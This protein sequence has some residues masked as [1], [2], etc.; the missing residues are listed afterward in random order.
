VNVAHPDPSGHPVPLRGHARLRKRL[1]ELEA[2][3]GRA[4]PGMLR[5]ALDAL[6]ESAAALEDAAEALARQEREAE[7]ERTRLQGQLQRAQRLESIGR[8]AGGI[9][10]DLNNLLGPIL[11]YA[12]LALQQVPPEE[13]LHADLREIQKLGERARQLGRHLLALGRRQPLTLRVFSLN[14]L[15]AELQSILRRTIREDIGLELALGAAPDSVRGDAAQIEQVLL[16]L[17]ANAQDAMPEGGTLTI[18]TENTLVGRTGTPPHP[19]LKPGPYVTLVVSDTGC[20]MD[21]ETLGHLFEPFFTTKGARGTGLGLASA[22]GVVRQHAGR[23]GVE[24][25]PQAGTTFRIYLPGVEDLPEPAPPPAPA[26]QTRGAETILVAEDEEG[27]RNLVSQ[28]LVRRGYEVLTARDGEEAL[29]LAGQH[30]GTIHLL[31]TDVIMPGMQGPDLFVKLRAV[32]PALRV[33]YMSGYSESVIGGRGITAAQMVQ[34]P[35]SL[36]ALTEGVRRALDAA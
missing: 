17:A 24:S 6:G 33:L 7:E 2:R 4:A 5:E 22:H 32:R 9:A 25:R 36:Q 21:A 3:A 29:W 27:V 35:F 8:L 13:Q 34:K 19:D 28:I 16:N 20:G 31:L 15:L 12:E 14:A 26:G 11:G 18:R 30:R 10:H 1:E 23:I